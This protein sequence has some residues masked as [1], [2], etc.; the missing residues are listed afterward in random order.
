[1]ATFFRT[2]HSASVHDRDG[3]PGIAVLVGHDHH[4]PLGIFRQG[5]FAHCVTNRANIDFMVVHE[6]A[7][8]RCDT[9]TDTRFF[10]F[11]EAVDAVGR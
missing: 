9:D 2:G 8:L 3:D 11:P 6:H 5:A 1:M 4:P 10:L 7:V